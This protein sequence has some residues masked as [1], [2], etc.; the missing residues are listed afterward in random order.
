M[1]CTPGKKHDANPSHIAALEKM[2]V[3]KPLKLYYLV[4][5]ERFGNFLTDPEPEMT[6]NLTSIFHVL[7]PN[8]HEE[9]V[10][11]DEEESDD[12]SD[13]SH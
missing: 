10:S 7:I 6:S 8:P 4:L 9:Q 11:H 12:E 2:L 13:R 1:Q 3:G 5:A